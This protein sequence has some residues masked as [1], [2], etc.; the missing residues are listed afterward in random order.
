[1]KKPPSGSAANN[2]RYKDY[3]LKDVMQFILPFMKVKPQ[4]SNLED[5][6]DKD[7][8]NSDIDIVDTNINQDNS[9]V[10]LHDETQYTSKESYKKKE[11]RCVTR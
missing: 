11:S 9:D 5:T 7:E 4:S 10:S 2:K 3:Y 8:Q 6:E 1:M